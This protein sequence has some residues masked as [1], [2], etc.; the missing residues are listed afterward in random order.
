MEN[1]EL[2]LM[3]SCFRLQRTNRAM[4]GVAIFEKDF[5]GLRA[6]KIRKTNVNHFNRLFCKDHLN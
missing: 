4:R 5:S 2:R 6:R 1:I 3:F